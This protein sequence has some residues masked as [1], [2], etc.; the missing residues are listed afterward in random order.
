M[1]LQA[2]SS[3][4]S[5]GRE[6]RNGHGPKEEKRARERPRSA[7]GRATM[8]H[9]EEAAGFTV[10]SDHPEL[11]AIH[12]TR[13]GSGETVPR[14][15]QLLIVGSPAVFDFILQGAEGRGA[16]RVAFLLLNSE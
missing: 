3:S 2:A 4:G 7:I 8:D 15:R 9:E 14:D 12:L 13:N 1:F 10:A 16:V 5:R 6:L 11:F